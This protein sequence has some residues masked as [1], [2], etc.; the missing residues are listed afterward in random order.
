MQVKPLFRG[1]VCALLVLVL[2]SWSAAQ[3]SGNYTIDPAGSG[4]T[5][6]TTFAAASAALSAGV[7]GPV[8]F[9]VASTTF[10]ESVVFNPVTGASST[11]TIT[12]IATGTPAVID[13]NAASDGLT[14]NT[15]CSYFV[16]DN[17]VV[18]GFTRYGLYL[19]G[20]S[21]SASPTFCK[22]LNLTV[23]APSSTS[24]SVNAVRNYYGNDN[25]FEN[26]KFM[27]GGYCAY[28]QQQNRCIYRACE[29]DGKGTASRL[30]APY[31][32][33]DADNLWENCFF[34]D[35]GPSGLGVYINLSQYGGMFWHNVVIV[36]T[37][38][39]AVHL[40]GCCAWSRAN[41]FRNNIV[42]NLGTGVCIKYGFRSPV[43]EY[44]DA[45]YNCY[46]APNGQAC[47]LESGTG[48]TKG[49]L[50]AWKAYFNANRAALVPQTG[51]GPIPT[52]A[53]ARWDDNSME[54]NP[55][56]VSMTAPYD[57]HL[58]G[59]SPCLDAGTTQYVA[60]NWISYNPAYV[61]ANDFEGD[62]RPAT[63][64][65][66][67]ADEVVVRIIGSGSGLPGTT[68]NFSLFSPSDAGLPYQVGSSFGNGPIPIDTRK[69][70]LSPD[71]LLAL[72]VGGLLPTIFQGYVGL[73]DA[74]GNG[75]A[76]LNIPAI[77]QLKGLRV[78][79]AFLTLK[80]S[81]PSGVSNISN[82]F[83]FT[84]Q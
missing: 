74:S 52:P 23:D 2:A 3:L 70:G 73:L 1:A 80:A 44:N 4:P 71:A 19:N 65:D 12:F 27:G 66:I 83:L 53:Q 77:P 7:S 64:V 8:V 24:S 14:L 16:F 72:S 35:C 38:Q 78:Y 32:S 17:L 50:A 59:A 22:F 18:K 42:V 61:V 51:S 62:P 9:K 79:T 25:L 60:G 30:C 28:S 69:I 47:E 40:G 75:S 67:G 49:T 26:C 11:N 57:I 54:A 34:H 84:I 10:M 46:Y 15:T 36:T 39:N 82:S 41:S 6:Y 5:N 68:I 21:G 43:L 13:A 56:L 76:K 33:N 63:N 29:I 20:T 45:D 48:F 31:N 37:S 55:G 81:A 58:T